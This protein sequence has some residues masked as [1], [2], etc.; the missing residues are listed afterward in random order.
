ML[1]AVSPWVGSFTD[2]YGE[3][4]FIMKN[5]FCML[6]ARVSGGVRCASYYV[7]EYD[8]KAMGCLDAGKHIITY[9]NI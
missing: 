8:F 5:G 2:Q 4:A 9:N 3:G 1:P 7:T 6:E